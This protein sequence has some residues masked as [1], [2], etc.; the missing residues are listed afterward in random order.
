MSLRPCL[1]A[2]LLLSLSGCAG[3]IRSM[4]YYPPT[5]PLS[6]TGLPSGARMVEV[7]TADGLALK[8]V[9]VPGEAAQPL[10]L[11]FHGNAASADAQAAWFAPLAVAGYSLLS[12]EYRGYSGN[13]GEPS[14][15]G[16][17][18]DADAYLARARALAGDAPVYVVG[19]SLG[20]GVAFDLSR[21][22]RLDML[23]TLSTFTSVVDMAPSWAGWLVP[24]KYDNRNAVAVSDVPLLILHGRDDGV[25]PFAHGEALA[26]AA[27]AAG[28]RHLFMPVAGDHNPDVGDILAGLRVAE[29][30]LS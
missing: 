18:K 30:D 22:H 23:V 12:A 17:A 26:R 9:H 27:D 15:E 25:V 19:H 24:D 2:L 6:L 13:P 3:M 11:V 28:R 7:E 29:R 4:I 10:L 21:R 14:Q 1:L 20:G 8:G 16:L 5:A